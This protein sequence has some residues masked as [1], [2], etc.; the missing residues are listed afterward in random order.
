MGLLLAGPWDA[1]WGPSPEGSASSRGDHSGQEAPRDVVTRGA[2]LT[3]GTVR[4]RNEGSSRPDL[5][6]GRSKTSL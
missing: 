5:E 1:S 6:L 4:Q 2:Q 3:Y